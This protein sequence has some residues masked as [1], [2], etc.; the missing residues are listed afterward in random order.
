MRENRKQKTQ[1]RREGNGKRA[2]YHQ[3]KVT[4]T[5]AYDLGHATVDVRHAIAEVRVKKEVREYL[6]KS[7]SW[8]GA[9]RFLGRVN[10]KGC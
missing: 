4:S 9:H 7:R 1:R 6:R 10:G 2:T 5:T 8:D 3:P